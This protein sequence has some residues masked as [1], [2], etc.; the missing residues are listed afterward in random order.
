MLCIKKIRKISWNS[1]QMLCSHCET[2]YDKE[3][4]NAYI[5]DVVCILGYNVMYSGT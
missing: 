2:E 5:V 4:E 3:L 1:E